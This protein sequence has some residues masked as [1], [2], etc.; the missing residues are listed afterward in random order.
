MVRCKD[1][2]LDDSFIKKLKICFMEYR[3]NIEKVLCPQNIEFGD[4][5][6]ASKA[7]KVLLQITD[8]NVSNTKR[9]QI[10][11]KM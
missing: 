8:G 5:Y 3:S 11:F 10:W 2:K 1:H 4:I 9:V 6:I 7:I